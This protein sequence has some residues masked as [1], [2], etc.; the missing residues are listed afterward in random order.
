MLALNGAVSLKLNLWLRNK[1]ILTVTEVHVHSTSMT[2]VTR[3]RYTKL[4]HYS[5]FPYFK[6]T[7]SCLT[8][9]TAMQSG[10]S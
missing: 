9:V 8:I 10:G 4:K 5:R 7:P 1:W 3:K 6:I 2:L